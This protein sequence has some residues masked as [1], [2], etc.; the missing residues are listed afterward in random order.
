M[1]SKR[2]KDEIIFN[3]FEVITED[4]KYNDIAQK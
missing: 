2:E 3:G 1:W 4:E